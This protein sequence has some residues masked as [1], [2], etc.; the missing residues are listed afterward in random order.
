[1][2]RDMLLEHVRDMSKERR[3]MDVDIGILVGSWAEFS[4]FC[5]AIDLPGSFQTSRKMSQNETPVLL[6]VLPG[7]GVFGAYA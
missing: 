5:D 4:I 7:A 2:A 6:D 3:T 1:M